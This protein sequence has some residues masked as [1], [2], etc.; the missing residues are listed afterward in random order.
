MVRYEKRY[1]EDAK[2]RA[3]EEVK[4]DMKSLE[5]RTISKPETEGTVQKTKGVSSAA[6]EQDLDVFLLGDLG[7]SDDGPGILF[8][9]SLF[10]NCYVV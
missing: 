8:V 9:L 3:A 5:D 4:D 7:D 6:T 10:P 1:N 2:R